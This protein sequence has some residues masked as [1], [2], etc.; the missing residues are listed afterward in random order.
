M[1]DETKLIR[2]S[3]E[4]KVKLDKIKVHERQS[5]DEVINILLKKA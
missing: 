3:E 2:I 5:Y 4:T 1:G